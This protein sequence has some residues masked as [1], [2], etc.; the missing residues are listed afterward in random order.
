MIADLLRI[1]VAG[2]EL[3]RELSA[4]GVQLGYLDLELGLHPELIPHELVQRGDQLIRLVERKLSHSELRV[5]RPKGPRSHRRGSRGRELQ[6]RSAHHQRAA[7]ER[8]A[9]VAEARGACRGAA[10]SSNRP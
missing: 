4:Q 1:P 3:S 7:T 8:E 2:D 6:S 10:D 5:R 9:R